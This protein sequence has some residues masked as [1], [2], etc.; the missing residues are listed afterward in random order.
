MGDATNEAVLAMGAA[1]GQKQSETATGRAAGLLRIGSPRVLSAQ[2]V[3]GESSES[4]AAEQYRLIRTRILQH[5]RRPRLIAVS[6]PGV[7]DG[8]TVTAVNL[9]RTLA[10]KDSITIAL[11]DADMRRSATHKYFDTECACGLADLL[12]AKCSLDEALC[13]PTEIP[14][15]HL[16]YSGQSPGNPSEL[17]E[18]PRWHALCAELRERYSFVIFDT[19]PMGLVADYDLIAAEADGVVM[20]VRPDH[21]VRSLWQKALAAV[22]SKKLLGVVVNCAPDWFLGRQ[23]GY[24]YHYA[25]KSEN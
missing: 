2:S 15:L 8:K 16:M 21:T 10:F 18:S 24:G 13:A 9:A 3:V 6:S 5:K 22:P 20:V 19:P 12:K 17:L 4:R 14:N 23:T 1:A 11:V 7:G 25:Y